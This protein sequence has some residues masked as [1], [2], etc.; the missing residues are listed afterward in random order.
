MSQIKAKHTGPE[1]KLRR[2]LSKLGLQ[3]RLH[4]NDVPGR[5]DVVFT[6]EKIAVFCDGDFWHGRQWE[7]RKTSGQFCVRKKYWC[8]KIEDNIRRDRR[9][10]RKLRDQGWTVLRYWAT[11][12]ETKG[13]MIAWEITLILRAKQRHRKKPMILKCWISRTKLKMEGV[14]CI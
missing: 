8:A 13:H 6:R 11:D 9:I 3:Y 5:P 7:K 12:I 2:C 4:K 10:N 14:R 1:L